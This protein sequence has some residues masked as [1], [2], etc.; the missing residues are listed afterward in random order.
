AVDLLHLL[1]Y[2][3]ITL[4][5]EEFRR[6][7]EDIRGRAPMLFDEAVNLVKILA[8]GLVDEDPEKELVRK[9]MEGLEIRT[10]GTLEHYY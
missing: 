3:A 8:Q 6:R 2:Y 10:P 5:K 4:P 1:E 7:V 9:V